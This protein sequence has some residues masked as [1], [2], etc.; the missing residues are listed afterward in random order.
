MTGVSSSP[1]PQ[2]NREPVVVSPP[3]EQAA[4]SA[5]KGRVKVPHGPPPSR[6]PPPPPPARPPLP[7]STVLAN[8]G[9]PPP[10]PPL[11]SKTTAVQTNV[12]QP[13]AEPTNLGHTKGH[14]VSIRQ[15]V[16]KGVSF[17]QSLKLFHIEKKLG[18]SPSPTKKA[19][20]KAPPER[21][22]SQNLSCQGLPVGTETLTRHDTMLEQKTIVEAQI[23]QISGELKSLEKSD[24]RRHALEV[25]LSFLF[26][27]FRT[28]LD[29]ISDDQLWIKTCDFRDNV[30]ERA[31]APEAQ[32]L[33]GRELWAHVTQSW[34]PGLVNLRHQKVDTSDA[35][36][37]LSGEVYEWSRS[38][39]IMDPRNGFTDLREMEDLLKN[40]SH[41]GEAKEKLAKLQALA[42]QKGLTEE[43]KKSLDEA[44]LKMVELLTKSQH[45]YTKAARLEELQELA[46]KSCLTEE[47]RKSLTEAIDAI[48][49][50]VTN[51]KDGPNVKEKLLRLKALANVAVE[52]DK[53]SAQGDYLEQA[54]YIITD[55]LTKNA[56]GPTMRGKLEE[57]H[58]L[59]GME[60]LTVQQKALLQETR[61]ALET[62]LKQD[63]YS[64]P[65]RSAKLQELRALASQKGLNEMQKASLEYAISQ[66]EPPEGKG[67][68][69]LETAVA[70]REQALTNQM[71]QVLMTHIETIA[72]DQLDTMDTLSI[73]HLLLLN[74]NKKDFGKEGWMHD[75]T[76]EIQDTMAIYER[77]HGKT[78]CFDGTGPFEDLNGVI[79]MPQT[80]LGK[81][82]K[83]KEIKL[84]TAVVNLS[85]QGDPDRQ[86]VSRQL[87]APGWNRIDKEVFATIPAEKKKQLRGYYDRAS[88]SPES[89]AASR[90]HLQRMAERAPRTPQERLLKAYALF[91]LATL[92]F[93][94][95]PANPSYDNATQLSQ[96]L[97]LAG[98]PFFISCMGAKDRTGLTSAG[99]TYA[100]VSADRSLNKKD[101]S[102]LSSQLL[103]EQG[104]ESRAAAENVFGMTTLKITDAPSWVHSLNYQFRQA[105]DWLSAQVHGR[106]Y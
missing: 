65:K 89:A 70:E 95:D 99:T 60:G 94:K 79:H 33:H 87:G 72:P 69:P 66:L 39:V 47:Q 74:P 62:F 2:G 106:R 50:F 6:P 27:S 98:V 3:Q 57:L 90:Y 76:H 85:V 102:E 88:R 13:P 23:N 83:P 73:V 61:L 105:T 1:A 28:I 25:K 100:L 12:L 24:P 29:A 48:K 75:E 77:F 5:L 49:P 56:D 42:G 7:P 40:D 41:S 58:T 15:S 31:D 97:A 84:S 96:A 22:L 17:L 71:F 68:D 18:S 38:G 46:K 16:N 86:H 59:E 91:L 36:T 104:V 9:S 55:L 20:P 21:E 67:P 34:V 10:D 78:L 8:K 35:K 30:K 82:N 81:D 32:K 14:T 37:A 93:Q 43:Q 4:P 92:N 101:Q 44:V 53:E 54:V 103:S 26:R 11:V 80:L 45:A 63:R 52:K 51:N 19:A 64:G